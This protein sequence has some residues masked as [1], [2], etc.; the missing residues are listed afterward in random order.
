V[1]AS[2]QIVVPNADAGVPPAPARQ[3]AP[4]VVRLGDMVVD[5]AARRVIPTGDG[6]QGLDIRLTPTEWHLLEAASSAW[7]AAISIRR[8]RPMLHRR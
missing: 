8:R 6:G 2:T 5:L 3:H 4:E 1:L 7:I